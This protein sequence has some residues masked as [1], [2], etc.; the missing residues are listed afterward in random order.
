MCS[1]WDSQ[2]VSGLP[3]GVSILVKTK[4]CERRLLCLPFG[5]TKPGYNI[6]VTESHFPTI[7]VKQYA[8][9]TS[10]WFEVEN[11]SKCDDLL[12]SGTHAPAFLSV[13]FSDFSYPPVWP[14]QTPQT[15]APTPVA[16][17]GSLHTALP[18]WKP[19]T[20]QPGD[21]LGVYTTKPR[22]PNYISSETLDVPAN[23]LETSRLLLTKRTIISG[24]LASDL[25]FFSLGI[26][27]PI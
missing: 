16:P 19:G 11:V 14:Q 21:R 8:H 4:T 15:S 3:G 2:T 23:P 24:R 13:V 20:F 22:M 5:C 27:V 25:V 18:A 17:C 9:F 26:P 1:G 7:Y 10:A 6:G 12:V